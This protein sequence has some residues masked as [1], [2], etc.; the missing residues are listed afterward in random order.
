M[1]TLPI[2]PNPII[3]FFSFFLD[4][5]LLYFINQIVSDAGGSSIIL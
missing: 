3:T 4:P 5:I 1:S 2:N